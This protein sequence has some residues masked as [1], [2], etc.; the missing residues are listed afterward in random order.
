MTQVHIQAIRPQILSHRTAF[1]GKDNAR[2]NARHHLA[3]GGSRLRRMVAAAGM[4]VLSSEGHRFQ[5][6]QLVNPDAKGQKDRITF[7]T[8]LGILVLGCQ[9]SGL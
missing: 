4:P 6:R 2:A 3:H 1:G 8:A 9:K 5:Y 7:A